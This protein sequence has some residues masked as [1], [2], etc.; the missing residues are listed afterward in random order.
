MAV[1]SIQ[2]SNQMISRMEC[3]CTDN[4]SQGT[5]QECHWMS[6]AWNS[7][8]TRERLNGAELH[9]AFACE[10]QNYWHS[11]D[12]VLC[13]GLNNLLKGQKVRQIQTELRDFKHY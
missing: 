2:Q 10:Y 13:A 9:H 6:T 1:A 8:K 11:M 4:Y 5:S 12:V 7:A 3:Q